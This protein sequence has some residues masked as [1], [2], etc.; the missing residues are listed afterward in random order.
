VHLMLCGH[1]E[2]TQKHSIMKTLE[3]YRKNGIT[4]L[5]KKRVGDI[6]M[7][8]SE[9]EPNKFSCEII[10]IQSHNGREAFGKHFPATEYPP[11]TNQWGALG[12]TAISPADAERI[13]KEKQT[14]SKD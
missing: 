8:E 2:L 7:F 11:S 1:L 14:L 9:A 10:K 4:F 3:T 5:L 13:F 6:A 12:W